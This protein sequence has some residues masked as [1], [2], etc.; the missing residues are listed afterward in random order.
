MRQLSPGSS[1]CWGRTASPPAD[2]AGR[3]W[4]TLLGYGQQK[5]DLELWTR[6]LDG[7]KEAYAGQAALVG[8]VK[9][10][11]K[12]MEALRQKLA[13][14]AKEEADSEENKK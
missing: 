5:E 12:A 4:Q 2:I 7:M 9:T 14:A 10:Q 6:A 13:E 1:S 3:V 8:F 11:E